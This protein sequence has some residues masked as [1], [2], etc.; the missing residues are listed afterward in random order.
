MKEKQPLIT[1]NR[2]VWFLCGL[3]CISVAVD[4][5]YDD[6]PFLMV[7]SGFGALWSPVMIIKDAEA[8]TWVMST[9][10]FVAVLVF[11]S[12][13]IGAAFP[14]W[15]VMILCAIWMVMEHKFLQHKEESR[16]NERLE[17]FKR[18]EDQ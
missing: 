18:G 12:A 5:Y 4:A 17:K 1:F 11:A 15:I 13:I 2:I 8:K 10:L 16:R 7:L 6:E 14:L 9:A 3:L